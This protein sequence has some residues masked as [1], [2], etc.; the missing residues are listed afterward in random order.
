MLTERQHAVLKFIYAYQMQFGY[1]PTIRE[2]LSGIGLR[3][4]SAVKHHLDHLQERGYLS[5][6]QARARAYSLTRKAYLALG[7]EVQQMARA[8]IAS[9]HAHFTHLE[10]S[11]LHQE[12]ARLRRTN[13]LLRLEIQ[14]LKGA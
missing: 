10:I 12:V 9:E 5:I 2:L 7:V 14:R 11:Q 6:E 3:S 13:R 8:A 1:V 4:T